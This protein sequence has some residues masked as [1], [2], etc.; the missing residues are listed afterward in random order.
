MTDLRSSWD[1]LVA[2][3]NAPAREA[4]AAY[5]SRFAR[6]DVSYVDPSASLRGANAYI[7]Y[8]MDVEAMNPGGGIETV[9]FVSHHGRSL[10]TW[11]AIDSSGIRI[12]EG[13]SYVEYDDAGR[14]VAIATFFGK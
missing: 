6:E 2:A 5:F 3:L 11:N 14:M 8:L 1:L 12:G 9:A 7:D 13:T 10:A 4:K